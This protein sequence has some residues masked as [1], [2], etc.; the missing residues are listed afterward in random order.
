MLVLIKGA[1]DLATGVACRLYRSG[2]SVAM[3]ELAQPTAVR[4]TVS[5]SSAVAEGRAT[6]EGVT[7]VLAHGTEEIP[8][9]L[10]AGQIPILIDPEGKSVGLLRPCGVVDA[11]MAKKN[12]GTSLSDAPV[13]IALGPGFTAGR[14]CHYVIETKRGH[15][16]GRVIREGSAIPNTG[17]PGEIGGYTKERLLQAPCEGIFSPACSIGDLVQAGQAV[18]FVGETPLTAAISGI[19]RGILPAGTPVFPGMKAG[20]IDPRCKREHC[21]TISDKAR[22]LGG[23]VLEALL[24]GLSLIRQKE[25]QP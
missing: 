20:D 11:I 5:F 21:F 18:G 24:E 4:R 13:V 2:F 1:G 3:T 25:G 19:L 14:D 16:L 23:G 7:A 8:S 9:L 6:V 15:D 10:A 12:T 17:V 22:A